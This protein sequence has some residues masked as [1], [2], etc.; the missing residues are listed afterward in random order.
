MNDE[1][2]T[3][4]QNLAP[5]HAAEK[6]DGTVKFPADMSFPNMLWMKLARSPHAHARNLRN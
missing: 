5:V 1:L 4:G 3:V 2:S 6:A